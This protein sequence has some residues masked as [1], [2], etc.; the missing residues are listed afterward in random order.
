MEA[1]PHPPSLG[2]Q[3]LGAGLS[4]GNNTEDGSM[5]RNGTGDCV[6]DSACHIWCQAG[7]V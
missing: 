2:L 5:G 1:K 4:E 6:L 3:H 7:T